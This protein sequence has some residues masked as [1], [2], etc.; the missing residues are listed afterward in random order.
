MPTQK[1]RQS[2]AT[3]GVTG[4]TSGARLGDAVNAPSLLALFGL[5]GEPKLLLQRAGHGAPH[6]VALPAESL[7]MAR[8]GAVSDVSERRAEMPWRKLICTVVQFFTL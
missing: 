8:T 5:D 7:I 1:R 4:S 2:R 3:G 6:R